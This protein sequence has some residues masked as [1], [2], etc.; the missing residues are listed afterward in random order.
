[1]VP[2]GR[3]R[4]KE[5]RGNEGGNNIGEEE[6]EFLFLYFQCIYIVYFFCKWFDGSA[7]VSVRMQSPLQA[8]EEELRQA[9]HRVE[10]GV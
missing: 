1:M 5:E 3:R 10:R 7:P 8:D 9:G 6:T 2:A 4:G